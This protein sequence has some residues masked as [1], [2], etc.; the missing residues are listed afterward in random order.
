M[1]IMGW[2]VYPEEEYAMCSSETKEQAEV[3]IAYNYEYEGPS[4]PYTVYQ[5]RSP[6]IG[7]IDE[8]LKK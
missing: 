4:G 7:R 5:A 3:Y 2:P 6:L 8:W 1:T